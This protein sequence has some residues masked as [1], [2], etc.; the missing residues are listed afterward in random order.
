MYAFARYLAGAVAL[1]AAGAACGQ[2]ARYA[3]VPMAWA[4]LYPWFYRAEDG[5][6]KGFAV[7]LAE[8][9][10]DE[11]GFEVEPNDVGSFPAWLEAQS[12]GVSAL[13]PAVAELPNLIATNLFSVPVLM[14]DIRLAVR[15]EDA[16]SFEATALAGRRVGVLSPGAGSDPELLPG[17]EIFRFSDVANAVL[18]LLAGEVDA[19]SAEATFVFAEA[20]RARLDHR[21][22]F[23]DAP[24]QRVERVVALHESRA[25]LLEPINE[26]LGRMEADG[27]LDRLRAR[28][29]AKIPEKA[30]DVLTVGVYNSPPFQV[31]E[32]DG[33]VS[34]FGV[35]V[36]HDLAELS[37]LSLRFEA[38][39][40]EE[41]LAGPSVGDF[42]V[43]PQTGVTPLRR[44]VMDFTLP[45]E[46]VPFSIFVRAGEEQ[47]VRDISD[48]AGRPVAALR[49]SILIPKLEQIADLDLVY[50]DTYV[51]LA[52]SVLA[53]EADAFVFPLERAAVILEELQLT[54]DFDIAP[55]PFFVIERA[56]ALRFGLGG[57][58]ERLNAV[59]PRYVISDQYAALR[60]EHFGEPPFWT[61]VRLLVYLAAVGVV[62]LLGIVVGLLAQFRA[63]ARAAEAEARALAADRLAAQQGRELETIFNAATSG[64]VAVN[65]SGEVVRANT[66]GRHML[67]GISDPTPF[68]WPETI[69][70]LE[71]QTMKR[72]EA[73]ADPLR[74]A[75]A[76]N[77]LHQ[78]THLMQR[79]Q[80]GED[81]RYVRVDTARLSLDDD[82][83]L[84]V[85][86]LDDVSDQERSRQV[87]ER[88]SRL[89]AL[90]QLTGGI[91]HD[92]NNILTS[93]LYSV[94]LAARSED[95]QERFE[96]LKEAQ[97][98]IDRGR[99][100]T[101]RLLAFARRQ[102]G[103]SDGRPVR[104]IL[105]DFKNLIRPMLE[106]TIEI[107][108]ELEEP[109]LVVYCDQTQLE[110]AL[111]NLVLNSRDAILLS[112]KGDR[113]TLRARAVADLDDPPADLRQ[114]SGASLRY[115]EL[116]VAD[117]GPGMEK[118]TLARAIDPFFTTKETGSG[119]GLGLA[120][121][122]GFARQ[123]G[124]SFRIYSEIGLGTTVFLTLPRGTESGLRE[125]AVA[126]EVI[127]S[128]QG[129]TVLLVED[130]LQILTVTSKLLRDIGYTVL[131]AASGREAFKI[132]QSG[133][134][135][136]L[137]LTDVVMPGDMGGFELAKRVREERPNVPVIYLSGYTGFT[138]SEMGA[139]VAPLLQKPAPVA[140]LARAVSQA[141]TEERHNG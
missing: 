110:S 54:D 139:V 42:D 115:V 58:R 33:S 4:D 137:L 51:D 101:S 73:S 26:A 107:T 135:F 118:E 94:V 36:L 18:A 96:N 63:R 19:I 67:G 104:D 90:G 16:G 17:A 78:E 77:Q 20:R 74:R 43:M 134:D 68:P 91:A 32:S 85:L 119:T 34:G 45:I 35:E 25:E 79:V 121:V 70:F 11:A 97:T 72:L 24:L 5:A 64:I 41:W 126:A 53:G 102:P 39:T 100:L 49:S 55:E 9:L 112:G 13:L 76:G 129:Q 127:A 114:D 71:A 22:T 86:V 92:F 14:T 84:I 138:A 59:I 109:G 60:E 46:K 30:P 111:M 128:G 124:G 7:E 98:S 3:P 62:L 83:D 28:Y 108:T 38:V 1:V 88:K 99:S 131:T 47:E 125:A 81:R 95:S 6:L 48:L 61:P 132:V 141:L 23:V 56:I 103:L 15:A 120:M 93:L 2:E 10:G 52:K 116:S 113:I 50:V 69:Q 89:D 140:E 105:D 106:A 66:V 27:R 123:S 80:A 130:D 65:L 117:N 133:S 57:I 29:A 31:V 12:S 122:Y 8:A 21:I 40:R 136:D 75:L 37:G 82:E 87:V 44:G